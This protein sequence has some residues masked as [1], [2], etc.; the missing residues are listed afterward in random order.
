MQSSLLVLLLGCAGKMVQATSVAA[1]PDC[2]PAEG[3]MFWEEGQVTLTWTRTK[4]DAVSGWYVGDVPG[5]G[6]YISSAGRLAVAQN[7][8]FSLPEPTPVELVCAVEELD[9]RVALT[10]PPSPSRGAVPP[11]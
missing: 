3:V 1:V 2:A 10:G 5:F 9:V 6:C 7:V 4:V 11:N 8:C